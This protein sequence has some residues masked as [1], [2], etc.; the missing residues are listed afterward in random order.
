MDDNGLFPGS[1]KLAGAGGGTFPDVF[2]GME[3]SSISLLRI[4]P[5]LGERN[6]E[7]KYQLIVEVMETAFRSRSTIE[8]WL[9][10]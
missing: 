1:M 6:F 8:M 10:P 2:V 4:I 9:V 3:K 5:V 7:P